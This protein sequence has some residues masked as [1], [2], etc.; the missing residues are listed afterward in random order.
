M[1]AG[2]AAGLA[3]RA[4]AA[5]V[6]SPEASL[7]E[8]TAL[9]AALAGR[10]VVGVVPW[11]EEIRSAER[12]GRPAI[13]LVGGELLQC[14]EAILQKLCSRQPAIHSEGKLQTTI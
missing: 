7:P 11:S 12:Q 6:A 10:E 4:P 3:G 2:V 8:L 13:E 14:F 1:A 9:G 5:V